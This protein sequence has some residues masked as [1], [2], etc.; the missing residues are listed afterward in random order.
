[1]DE[2]PT[3]TAAAAPAAS[4]RQVLFA[5]LVGMAATTFPISVLAASL[6]SIAREFGTTESTIAWVVSLPTLGFA[7]AMPVLGKMGDLYGHRKVY[8]WG[9]TAATLFAALTA[10]AWDAPSLIVLRTLGQM[11]GAATTPAA[12]ALIMTVYP[13]EDRVRAMGWWS[14]V[15]A[16]SPTIGLVA[17]GPIIELIGWRPLFLIQALGGLAAVVAARRVLPETTRREARGFDIPGAATLGLGIAALLVA[18][19]Q[20][21]QLGWTSPAIMTAFVL[22]PVLL[23]VFIRIEG[24]SPSPLLPLGMFRRRNYTVSVSAQF[25]KQTAYMGGFVLS[26]FLLDT[27]FGYSATMITLIMVSRPLAFSLAGPMSGR[28]TPVIG[29]RSAGILATATMAA[30]MVVLAYGAGTRQIL[31]VVIGLV[32]SGAGNGFGQPPFQASM[33]NAVDEEDLGIASAA[34]NVIGQIG[35]AVGITLMTTLRSVAET[36][37]TGFAIAYWTGAAIATIAVF[38]AFALESTPRGVLVAADVADPAV[39]R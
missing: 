38:I 28:I 37:A 33:A 32:M 6:P 22:A 7:V 9:F 34:K 12:M 23:V 35:A 24:R 10:L 1:V 36:P 5:L 30:S 27:E 17:G 4:R 19:N 2:S 14:L 21:D 13:R 3:V 25:F 26:P 16:G 8:L 39:D 31:P 29:E 18:V 11:C 20:G 15:T